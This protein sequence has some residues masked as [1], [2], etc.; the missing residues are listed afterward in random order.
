MLRPPAAGLLVACTLMAAS[1]SLTVLAAPAQSRGRVIHVAVTDKDGLPV[2]DLRPEE[3]QIKEGGREQ[4]VVSAAIASDRVRIALIVADGG[5]GAFQLGVAHFIQD[6][7]EHA[8]FAIFSVLVQPERIVDYSHDVGELRAA[9]NRLGVRTRA[10]QGGQVLEAIMDAAKEVRGEAERSAIVVMRV[11]GE[12]PT[13][14]RGNDVRN[15]LRRRGTVLYAVSTIGAQRAAPSQIAGTD[16]IAVQRGQLADAEIAEGAFNLQLVLGDG[17]K[18]SGGRHEQVVST[19]LV[20]TMQQIARELKNQYAVTY[21]LPDGMKPSDR[22]EVKV[23]R[24]DLKV[25]AP[26]RI[27]A[28]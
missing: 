15:E 23:T 26:T 14:L 6:L 3:F 10:Q 28:E 16:A 4:Q 9:V 19:T 13:T 21:T 12:A 20:G 8:D 17:S 5:T 1:P 18:D 27:P 25:H 2:T 22:L 11:G 24:R 7:L